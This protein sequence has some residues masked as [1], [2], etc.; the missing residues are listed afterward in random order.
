MSGAKEIPCVSLSRAHSKAAGNTEAAEAVTRFLPD[1]GGLSDA[2]SGKSPPFVVEAVANY[3]E[4][5]AKTPIVPATAPARRVAV[6][7][8]CAQLLGD[9]SAAYGL[10]ASMISLPVL[11]WP[12]DFQFRQNP[13]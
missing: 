10:V 13:F 9:E 8:T 2:R 1:D 5:V 4:P 7:R 3:V 6:D 12:N 11:L